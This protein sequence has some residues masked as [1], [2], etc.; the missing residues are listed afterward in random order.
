MGTSGSSKGPGTSSPLV[1]AWAAIDGKGPVPP[2][3][4]PRFTAFRSNLGRFVSGGDGA[5]LRGALRHYASTATGG[6]SIGPRRFGAMAQAGGALFAALSSMASGATDVTV[7]GVDL[8]ALNAADTDVAIQ[9]IAR[10]LTPANGDAE[11]IRAAS[12]RAGGATRSA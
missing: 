2:P 3:D 1:P 4:G 7:G 12:S 8:S 11:K 6:K 9:E 10:A 5:D